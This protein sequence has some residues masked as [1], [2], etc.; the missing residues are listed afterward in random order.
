MG[1][2]HPTQQ[3]KSVFSSDGPP[4]LNETQP[5]EL[6]E[7]GE[8][9]LRYEVLMDTLHS[10]CGAVQTYGIDFIIEKLEELEPMYPLLKEM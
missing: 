4:V 8:A 7:G 5:A 9:S 10:F 1:K 6:A 2:Q 3:S